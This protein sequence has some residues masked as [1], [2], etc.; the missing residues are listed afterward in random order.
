MKN[1][2]RLLDDYK[3]YGKLFQVDP[4]SNYDVTL[5]ITKYNNLKIILK[6]ETELTC[7]I[8]FILEQQ[9]KRMKR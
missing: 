9:L 1:C 7:K 2:I 3:T 4:C 6:T 5:K 8:F